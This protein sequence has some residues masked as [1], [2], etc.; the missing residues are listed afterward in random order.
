[1]TANPPKNAILIP[2]RLFNSFAETVN[3]S[4]GGADGISDHVVP[5]FVSVS[6]IFS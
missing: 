1:M 5:T 6:V 3:A 2:L 4:D